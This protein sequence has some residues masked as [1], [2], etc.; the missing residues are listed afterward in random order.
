VQRA[1]PAT[2]PSLA[3]EE[4]LAAADQLA[5]GLSV[6]ACGVAA[7]SR[8]ARFAFVRP[9]GPEALRCWRHGPVY[10]PVLRQAMRV[11][12]VV[13]TVLF[14]INQA[15]VVLRGHLTLAVAGKI[16]LTYLVPFC[17]STYSALGVNRLRPRSAGSGARLSEPVP[18]RA[19]E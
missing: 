12:A 13:G 16:G 8:R 6:P 2:S 17:V 9:E 3:A 10:G 4:Q 18:A 19:D 7:C 11:A 15:D 14:A 1:L 5:G